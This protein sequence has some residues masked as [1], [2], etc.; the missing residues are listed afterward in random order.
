VDDSIEKRQTL[1]VVAGFCKTHIKA[2]SIYTKLEKEFCEENKID[3]PVG[4][5]SYKKHQS[6][7][8][9]LHHLA[10][11]LAKKSAKTH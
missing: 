8:N 10:G 2:F 6:S 3:W 9:K 4:S 7:F 5:L 1:F 11:Q